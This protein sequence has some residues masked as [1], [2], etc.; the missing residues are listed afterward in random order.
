MSKKSP[1]RKKRGIF[2]ISFINILLSYEIP[3]DRRVAF[4]QNPETYRPRDA[5]HMIT[6]W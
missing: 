5:H 4:F 2:L 3:C 6:R 1:R